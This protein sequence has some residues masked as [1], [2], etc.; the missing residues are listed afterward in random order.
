[1]QL[2]AIEMAMKQAVAVLLAVMVVVF[3]VSVQDVNAARPIASPAPAPEF[4]EGPGYAPEYAPSYAPSYS[5]LYAPEAAPSY[6]PSMETPAY[7]PG[8]VSGE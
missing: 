5:P 2:C 4:P 3:A 6:G 1:M 8:P 7:A